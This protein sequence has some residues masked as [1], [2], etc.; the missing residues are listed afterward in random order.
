MRISK[1]I[2]YLFIFILSIFGS[3]SFAEDYSDSDITKVVML[4]SGN[5]F[6]DLPKKISKE[7]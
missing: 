3:F 7:V 4:G 6:P 2:I 1:S 5:P